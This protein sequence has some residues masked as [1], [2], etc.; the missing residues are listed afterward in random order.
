MTEGRGGGGELREPTRDVPAP[1]D[2]LLEASDDEV[3][4]AFWP[5]L[6]QMYPHLQESDVLAFQVSRVKRVFA[7]PT[8]GFTNPLPSTNP[9]RSK[10]TFVPAGV[11]SKMH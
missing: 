3:R 8:I 10:V 11:F 6:A 9:G 7:V 2:P 1:D 5:Y 4:A